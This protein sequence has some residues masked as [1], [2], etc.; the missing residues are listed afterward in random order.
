MDDAIQSGLIDYLLNY[1]VLG[2][3][4]II[5]FKFMQQYLHKQ[6]TR[7]QKNY[8]L[9]VQIMEENKQDNDKSQD[10][11]NDYLQ[12]E[13]K[14]LRVI[15]SEFKTVANDIKELITVIKE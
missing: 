3:A 15:V 14:E 7:D 2:I 13:N 9:M 10:S 6:D 8:D 11:F 5:L 12:N 1:G 4:A